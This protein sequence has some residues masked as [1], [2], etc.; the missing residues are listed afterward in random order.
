PAKCLKCRLQGVIEMETE[1]QEA[2]PV[3][4]HIT[5]DAKQLMRNR[6]E[7]FR[8]SFDNS[9]LNEIEIE[10]MDHEEDQHRSSCPYHEFREGRSFGFVSHRI[11]YRPR[12]PVLNLQDEP[13]SDV[14]QDCQDEHYFH[15]LY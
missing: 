13:V 9:Q 4:D 10:E 11:S 1:E 14:N 5:P 7:V 6:I 15:H 12:A 8:I 3:K 2:D